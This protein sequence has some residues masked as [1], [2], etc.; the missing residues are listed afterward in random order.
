MPGLGELLGILEIKEMRGRPRQA[1]A[2]HML[3]KLRDQASQ[4]QPSLYDRWITRARTAVCADDREIFAL[5]QEKYAL[6]ST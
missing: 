3:G 5:R 4:N 2:R 1:E 6:H